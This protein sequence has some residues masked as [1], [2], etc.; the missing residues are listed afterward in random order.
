MTKFKTFNQDNTN[1][2]TERTLVI[3]KPDGVQRSLIGEIIGRIERTG[4]KLTAM[5]MV[6][7]DA[8]LVEQHYTLDSTWM[9]RVGEK[10]IASYDKKGI[11]PPS[12]DPIV[13]ATNILKVLQ[14]YLTAGPVI[15]M[16]WQGMHAV[17]IV[18]KITGGTEPLTSDVGTIRGDLT[19]HSYQ[20]AD[21][22]GVS[23]KNLIHSSGSAAEADA[24]I[25]LWFSEEELVDY[26]LFNEAILYE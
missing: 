20:I 25:A 12:R 24:E 22:D 13:L 1:P 14:D 10:T 4:L 21:T 7:P 8:K 9:Q 15:C 17:G 6:R 11:E 3:I 5:K 26:K 23:V 2:K 16:V 18:R 19:I